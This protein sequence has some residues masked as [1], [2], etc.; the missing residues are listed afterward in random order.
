MRRPFIAGILCALLLAVVAVAILFLF[1]S[2]VDED[3]DSSFPNVPD[4]LTRIGPYSRGFTMTEKI[5]AYD[6]SLKAAQ[7]HVRKSRV[8]GFDSALY[9]RL[10]LDDLHVTVWKDGKRMLEFRKDRTSLPP[11][12]RSMEIDHPEIRYPDSMKG[13][14]KIKIDKE[15]KYLKIYRG[16]KAETWNLAQ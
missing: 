15:K 6:I 10:S 12:M 7:M 14:T 4:R 9:K 13:V 5:G 16:S 8:L 3:A 1:V 2:P 11:T